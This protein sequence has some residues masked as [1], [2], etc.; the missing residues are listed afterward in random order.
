MEEIALYELKQET[1]RRASAAGVGR[2]KKRCPDLQ[3]NRGEGRGLVRVRPR[4][5]G[6]LNGRPLKLFDRPLGRPFFGRCA[7]L[8]PRSRR[9]GDGAAPRRPGTMRAER[10]GTR[11][12]LPGET[13]ARCDARNNQRASIG[14][15]WRAIG[16]PQRHRGRVAK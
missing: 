5:W 10:T 15:R 3:S 14:G 9:L 7:V 13:P 8:L 1:G 16:R 12:G 6:A 2:Q 11:H 4:A